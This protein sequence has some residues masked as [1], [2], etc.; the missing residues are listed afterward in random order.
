M[1]P[2]IITKYV[3]IWDMY[4]IQYAS[5]YQM[6][7][8]TMLQYHPWVRYSF[9]VQ[10]KSMDFN[11]TVCKIPWYGFR[12]HTKLIF[13]NYHLSS[14]GEEPITNIYNFLEKRLLKY[15]PSFP[16]NK[17]VKPSFYLLTKTTLNQDTTNAD[18]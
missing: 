17:C 13:K 18:T 9:K 11:V 7:N 12:F 2:K 16:Y 15:L 1:Q 3:N 6:N 4:V 8:I 10:G 5:I 14:Y